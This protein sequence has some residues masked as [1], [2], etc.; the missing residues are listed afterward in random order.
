MEEGL[1][2]SVGV[3]NFN[4]SQLERLLSACRI[5]PA[6]NQVKACHRPAA[7]RRL[8][9]CLLRALELGWSRM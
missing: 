5:Q 8:S 6:V 2:K 1:V 9:R 7:E 3:S 4:V